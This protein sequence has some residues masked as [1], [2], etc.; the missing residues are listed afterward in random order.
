MNNTADN[1]VL[2]LTDGLKDIGWKAIDDRIM[3]GCSQSRP[4]CLPG[5]GLRFSGT[6][7]LENN[8]GFAS[9]RSDQGHFDLSKYSGLKIRVHGDGHT[10]K[11]SLRTDHYYDGVSYQAPF[12]TEAEVWQE[13]ITPFR[14]NLY[15]QIMH[16]VIRGSLP[17]YWTKVK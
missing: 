8:G 15:S 17:W 14:I 4:E 1:L 16:Q 7:R 6:V 5:V 13:I 2:D 12:A 10:Y 11:L 9:I 3:G